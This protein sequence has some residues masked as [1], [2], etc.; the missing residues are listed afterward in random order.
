MAYSG[1]KIPKDEIEQVLGKARKKLV[2]EIVSCLFTSLVKL[3][4][5]MFS[6]KKKQV[7]QNPWRK[8]KEIE[9]PA[10]DSGKKRLRSGLK[11]LV[12]SGHDAEETW[13]LDWTSTNHVKGPPKKW[14]SDQQVIMMHS[15]I[16]YFLRPWKQSF[17]PVLCLLL[18]EEIRHR[19]IGSLSLSY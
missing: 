9:F 14:L 16:P 7:F 4:L 15:S 2:H 1:E 5:D 3:S 13:F 17:E 18:M 11:S 8:S 12:K 6:A 10:S 19:F